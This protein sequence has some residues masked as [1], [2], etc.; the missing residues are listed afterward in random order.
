MLVLKENDHP[1]AQRGED[2]LLELKDVWINNSRLLAAHRPGHFRGDMLLFKATEVPQRFAGHDREQA[3]RPHV[4][5]TVDVR[6]VHAEHEQLLTVPAHVATIGGG[7]GGSLGRGGPQGVLTAF[8][9]QEA[10]GP[11]GSTSF[12]TSLSPE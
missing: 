10:L 1:L 4:S 9:A 11:P 6:P 8:P 3:W 2:V 5:G 12:E 7:R